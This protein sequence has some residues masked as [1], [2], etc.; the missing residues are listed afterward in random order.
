MHYSG[1]VHNNTQR[2]TNMQRQHVATETFTKMG[3]E[4][5]AHFDLVIDDDGD[6]W[7]SL[8]GEYVNG[9]SDMLPPRIEAKLYEM[10]EGTL[11]YLHEIGDGK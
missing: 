1:V 9:K 10:A 2:V 6:F 5:K 11:Q 4:F 3:I 7:L 8:S